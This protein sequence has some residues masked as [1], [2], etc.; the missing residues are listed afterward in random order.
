MRHRVVHEYLYVDRDV[1]WDVVT[2][3]LE[4]LITE[5]SKLLSE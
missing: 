2:A 5:L 3:D 1:V 4:P